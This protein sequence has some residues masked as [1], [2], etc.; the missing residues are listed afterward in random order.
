[1]QGAEAKGSARLPSEMPPVSVRPAGV[2][3]TH[4][5]GARVY[6]PTLER[7]PPPEPRPLGPTAA[8]QP[9]CLLSLAPQ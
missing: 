6:T 2:T 1:M 5:L 3:A 8:S 9:F 7:L 4:S